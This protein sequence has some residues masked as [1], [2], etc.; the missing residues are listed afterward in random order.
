MTDITDAIAL[1][2]SGDR[3]GARGRFEGIWARVSDNPSAFHECVL[4][5]YMADAQVE[6][7]EE[8][9]WD[10]RSIAAAKRCTDEDA[11]RYQHTLAMAA[12]MPSLHLNLAEDYRKLGNFEC[13][14]QHLAL[15]RESMQS[16]GD[17]GY[18]RMIRA[19]IESLGAKLQAI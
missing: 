2:H 16:L 8:L 11:R 5:H 12:F 17:D 3:A 13:S 10:L 4:A 15:A 18:G 19:G 14:K 7:A 6:I 9:S 1:L